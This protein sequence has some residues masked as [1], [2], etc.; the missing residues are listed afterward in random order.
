[1]SMLN[2]NRINL[3]FNVG[4]RENVMEPGLLGLVYLLAQQVNQA[5]CAW[6]TCW[7]SRLLWRCETEKP[8]G[9]REVIASDKLMQQQT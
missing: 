8:E 4:R 9:G 1:M 2:K 7:H 6:F 3:I 5:S